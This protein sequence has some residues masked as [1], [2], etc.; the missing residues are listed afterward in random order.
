MMDYMS[1]VRRVEHPVLQESTCT[2][3]ASDAGEAGE[4]Q[5]TDGDRDRYM[6]A[7]T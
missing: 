3:G 1:Q 7:L 2:D 4:E 6:T 5:D